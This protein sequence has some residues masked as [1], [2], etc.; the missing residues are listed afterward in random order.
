MAA[1]Q[2]RELILTAASTAF[3]ERGWLEVSVAEIGAAAGASEALVHRYFGTKA[4]L[5]AAVVEREALA[6][7]EAQRAAAAELGPD[8]GPREVLASSLTVYLEAI[9]SHPAG[10]LAVLRGGG[11]IPPEVVD[12]RLRVHG[13]YVAALVRLLGPDVSR[14]EIEGYLGWIDGACAAWVGNGCPAADTAEII[15]GALDTLVALRCR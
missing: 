2:R 3:V 6:R 8:A 5:L 10:W 4:G 7:L 14:Y 11:V 1:E 9:A 12:V 15:N 13:M